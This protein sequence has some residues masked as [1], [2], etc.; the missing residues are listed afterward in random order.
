MRW[1][2]FIPPA[3]VGSLIISFLSAFIFPWGWM[4]LA[5]VAGCYLVANLTASFITAAKKG[6]KYFFL[7]PL[8][9][10]ILHLSYGFGFLVGLVKFANRWG[11]KTGKVPAG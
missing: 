5:L 1:R 11:D 2:Q 7:L 10:S 8:T 9:F 3:F 4:F 6:W